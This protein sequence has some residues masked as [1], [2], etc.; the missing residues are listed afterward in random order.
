MPED[1]QIREDPQIIEVYS[2]GDITLDDLRS[3]LER[4]A[5]I[6]Q[7]RGL[8]KVLVDATEETSL[9]STLPLFQFGSELAESIRH[10]KFAVVV[11]DNQRED[12]HFLR[13]VLFNRGG[14]ME[15][16]DSEEKALNWLRNNTDE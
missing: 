1:V 9:P 2:Y 8:C 5:H 12:M 6:Y 13:T 3:S 7:N 10:L 14:Q 4:I 11:T 15:I 16:F